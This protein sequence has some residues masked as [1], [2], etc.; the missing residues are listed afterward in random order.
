[1]EARLG[2]LEFVLLTDGQFERFSDYKGGTVDRTPNLMVLIPGTSYHGDEVRQFAIEK[3]SDIGFEAEK[4]AAPMDFT[5]VSMGF[6]D[7]AHLERVIAKLGMKEATIFGV[8]GT[9]PSANQEALRT[10]SWVLGVFWDIERN[11][12]S[13]YPTPPE[14]TYGGQP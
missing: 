9:V 11:L 1:M 10:H 14:L 4:E 2:E 7:Q 8:S 6:L 3:L 12:E 13:D 5:I